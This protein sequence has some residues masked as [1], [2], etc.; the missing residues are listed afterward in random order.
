MFRPAVSFLL[1]A[2]L[3]ACAAPAHESWTPGSRGSVS[4]RG[5]HS[6]LIMGE[7]ADPDTIPRND[8]SFARA[9]NAFS[10]ELSARGFSVYD[11]TAVTLDT[12]AQ[13]RVRRTD[14]EVI[15]IAKGVRRPPIDTVVLF[16][17]YPHTTDKPHTHELHLRTVGRL[18]SV[19][20]GRRLGNF[21]VSHQVNVRP[22]CRD[23]CRAEAIG[24]IARILSQDVGDILSEKLAY[25]QRGGRAVSARGD[26]GLARGLTLIFDDFNDAEVRRMEDYLVIFSGYR[27]HRPTTVLGRY[28]EYWYQTTITDARMK[29]N[30]SRM[31]EELDLR[32][33][34]TFSGNTYKMRQIRLP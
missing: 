12:H 6:L 14:A 17:L 4:D 31:L 26:G 13:G 28:H 25:R 11:E 22:D 21:E 7:D 32:A 27:S 30:L 19:Q 34:I 1:L 2:A 18:L 8:R 23:G 24:R 33:R 9:L 29:R 5:A 10:T 3:G 15:D 16:T 20:D